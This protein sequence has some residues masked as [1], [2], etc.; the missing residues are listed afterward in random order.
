MNEISVIKKSNMET[1]HDITTADRSRLLSK[2]VG[3]T[4]S[5]GSSS[6]DP[7]HEPSESNKTSIKGDI[8]TRAFGKMKDTKLP[9][10]VPTSSVI[11]KT[12]QGSS[13]Q[14][15]RHVSS[16]SHILLS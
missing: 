6:F 2:M 8:M 4:E 10:L 13:P 7:D 1:T 3:Q 5:I 14:D 15:E 11:E 12:T 16:S 9:A